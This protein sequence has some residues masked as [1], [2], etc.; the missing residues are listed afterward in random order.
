M[1]V[2]SSSIGSYHGVLVSDKE[3]GQ[4]PVVFEGLWDPLEP[5]GNMKNAI[6][7]ALLVPLEHGVWGMDR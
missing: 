1:Y 4:W 7:P 3:Q 6:L 2:V 5:G